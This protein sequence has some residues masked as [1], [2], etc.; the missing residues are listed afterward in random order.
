LG[1]RPAPKERQGQ[2]KNK[3]SGDLPEEEMGEGLSVDRAAFLCKIYP[4]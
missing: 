1:Q 3:K 2:A 4:F